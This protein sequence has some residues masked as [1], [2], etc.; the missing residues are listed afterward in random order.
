MKG[1]DSHFQD[2]PDY[3]LKIT[4][5]I[6]EDK[7]VESIRKYYAKDMPLRSPDG[8]IYG[9][10]LVVKATYA[11]LNEFPDRQLLGEDVIWIGNEIDGYLSSHRILS[12]ATHQNDGVY[13]KATGKK[14]K[15][16]VIADC[17][18]KNN[19]VYDEWLVRDQGAIVRQL[20]MDPKIYA[21]NL[22]EMQ[23]G[24][25]KCNQPFNNSTDHEILYSQLPLSQDNAGT[26]YANFLENIFKGNFDI[27]SKSYDRSVNQ[28]QPGGF[29]GLGI[30]EAK[31]FWIKLKSSF[32]DSKFKIEHI[33]YL[34][35]KNQ[36]KKA[37]VRWSLE[38]KHSGTG[39][40]F[41]PSHA[42]VHIMGIS[43]VEFGPRGIKNEWVLFDEAIIWKQILLKTG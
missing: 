42:L 21:A 6:W 17:A 8:V 4:Y 3:I 20:G 34:E 5:Q 29:K 12:V 32:P 37:S 7:D 35:E 28:E 33:S 23:G 41:N 10:D 19:Q 43:Q 13:G 39:L 18:C 30:D 2:L 38:G 26:E 16:R 14:L 22:I 36:Y 31:D 9:S 24:K 27:F 1:F 40:F 15:Y 11:T 25:D